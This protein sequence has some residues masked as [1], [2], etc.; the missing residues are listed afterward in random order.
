MNAAYSRGL[1]SVLLG[2]LAVLGCGHDA[3]PLPPPVTV[4]IHGQ[5]TNLG[6]N[7]QPIPGAK[8]EL[9]EFW[10]EQPAAWTT[11]DHEGNYRLEYTCSSEFSETQTWIEASAVGYW[12]ASSSSGSADHFSDPPIFC[13]SEPQVINL[14][15]RSPPTFAI[16]GQITSSGADPV[17]IAGATV[18]LV[19]FYNPETVA[20]T[21]T[22]EAG[23]YELD[24]KYPYA[25][26]CEPTDDSGFVLEASADGYQ[27]ATTAAPHPDGPFVSD[28]PIYCTSEPQVINL[29]LQQ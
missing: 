27:T 14:S 17:P 22:D 8:I 10:H 5:I 26:P 6:S 13:T 11:T 28:P 24:Y 4:S 21:T 7:P 25:S 20:T 12:M 9:H 23:N 3:G 19:R 15:L 16:R 18:R 1:Y 29:S 2:A